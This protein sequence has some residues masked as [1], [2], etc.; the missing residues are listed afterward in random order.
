MTENCERYGSLVLQ[1]CQLSL[2]NTTPLF[3]KLLLLACDWHKLKLNIRTYEV[4]LWRVSVTI[5][6]HGNATI[7]S[8]CIVFDIDVVG[9]NIKRFTVAVEI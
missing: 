3:P 6:C 5:F 2:Y 8:L 7:R 1:S 9:N 4:T